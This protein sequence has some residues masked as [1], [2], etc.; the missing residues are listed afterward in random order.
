MTSSTPPSASPDA[1]RRLAL[2]WDP[3]QPSG[4][5][6]K[7]RLTL[8]EVVAAGTAVV[9]ETGLDGLSMRKVAAQ[10]GVGAMTLYTYVPGRTELVDLMIDRAFGELSL[11]EPGQPWRAALTRHAREH[12]DLYLRHPWILQTNMWRLPLA[13]HVL[14]AEEAGLRILADAGLPPARVVELVGLVDTYVRG[15]ARAAVAERSEDTES[16]QSNDDYWDSMSDFWTTYFDP[17]R[18]PTMTRIWEAGG[19]ETGHASFD[20]TLDR[21]LDGI[22]QAIDRAAV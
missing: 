2:L 21:L 17:R 22:E 7:A 15:A 16:G 10:L 8:D 12:R 5:G 9:H 1:A 20:A 6:R 11:P 14:D 13:P 18:Y 4:R 3:P 19:F